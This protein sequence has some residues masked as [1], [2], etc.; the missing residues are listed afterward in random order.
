MGPKA[1]LSQVRAQPAELISAEETIRRADET[2]D[3]WRGLT[4]EAQGY[5]R[6]GYVERLRRLGYPMDV[7]GRWLDRRTRPAPK[8][9]ATAIA[10]QSFVFRP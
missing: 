9:P 10:K 3:E 6:D 1:R 4:K 2:L 7:I 5:L 8:K